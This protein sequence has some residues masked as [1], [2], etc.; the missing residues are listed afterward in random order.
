MFAVNVDCIC[1]E[2]TREKTILQLKISG[3]K[4]TPSTTSVKLS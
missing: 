4:V 1:F 2:K 3:V